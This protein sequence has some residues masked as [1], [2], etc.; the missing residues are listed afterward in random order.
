M[1]ITKLQWLYEL[2]AKQRELMEP[3]EYE[4]E[5]EARH[6][7]LP[8]VQ[9]AFRNIFDENDERFETG[10]NLLFLPVSSGDIDP[11]TLHHVD[12]EAFEKLN[13]WCEEYNLPYRIK[14]HEDYIKGNA[15]STEYEDRVV[16]IGKIFEGIKKLEEYLLM[17]Y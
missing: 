15:H 13:R 1:D 11:P 17:K 16:S 14:S 12:V 9:Q 4:E 7:A 3:H 8:N 6:E 5:E 2:L 10:E